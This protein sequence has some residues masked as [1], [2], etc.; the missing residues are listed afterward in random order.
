MVN[1]VGIGSERRIVP[2]FANAGE[3]ATKVKAA[4]MIAK[5]NMAAPLSTYVI[6]ASARHQLTVMPR[7]LASIDLAQMPA[8]HGCSR[9]ELKT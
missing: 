3:E 5:R 6:L 1:S 4:T 2:P 9:S 7:S 8:L